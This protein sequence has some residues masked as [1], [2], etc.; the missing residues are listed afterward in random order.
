MTTWLSPLKTHFF[1]NCGGVF[2]SGELYSESSINF[3]EYFHG[4]YVFVNQFLFEITSHL[5]SHLVNCRWKAH[6]HGKNSTLGF[7]TL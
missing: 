2:K 4:S 5:S 1:L 6:A 3:Y 7:L